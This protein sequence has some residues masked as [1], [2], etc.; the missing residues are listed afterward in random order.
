MKFLSQVAQVDFSS[1]LEF[2]I[3]LRKHTYLNVLFDLFKIRE[4]TSVGQYQVYKFFV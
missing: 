1:G 2:L 3:G 4:N